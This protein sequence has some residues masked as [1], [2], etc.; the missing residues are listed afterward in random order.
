M[1]EEVFNDANAIHGSGLCICYMGPL[2]VNVWLIE[3]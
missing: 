1:I 2:V 3:I